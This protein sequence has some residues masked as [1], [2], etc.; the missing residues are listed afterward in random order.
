MTR[1]TMRGSTSYVPFTSTN[2]R[3]D[4]RFLYPADWQARETAGEGYDEVFILGPRNEESTYSA[5][6]VARVSRLH[7]PAT[8]ETLAETVVQRR[9]GT[10]G[11]RLISQTRGALEGVPAVETEITYTIPLPIRSVRAQPTPVM[12]RRII[13]KRTDRLYELIYGAAASD[14]HRF[15]EA[16][17]TAVRTFVF[18]EE[19]E[20]W[21][22]RPLLAFGASP[23]ASA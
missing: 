21:G 7:S 6:L 15:L 11:F 2:A 12:E 5:A 19:G 1:D 9:Q 3:L 23:A 13:L 16:F 17:R 18:R 10:S 22:R 14:Y 20:E 8:I 4:F